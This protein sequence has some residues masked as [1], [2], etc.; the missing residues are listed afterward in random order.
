[1]RHLLSLQHLSLEEIF[2]LFHMT[3]MYKRNTSKLNQ[4]IFVANLFFEPST[5]TKMSFTVAQRKLGFEVLNFTPEH[6]SMTKGES[7]YDT[8]KTFEALGAHMLIIRHAANH[9]MNDIEPYVNIPV[10]NAGAGEVEH[11]TQ[12]LLDAFTI[13]EAFGRLKHVNV[14]IAG[15]IKHSRVAR[16]NI[17]LLSRLGANIYVSGPKALMDHTLAYPYLPI[18]E[19]VRCADSL[20]LLRIQHERH[21]QILATENYLRHYGLTKAREKMMK[22]N[23]IILHPAPVNRGVEIDQNL[24]LCDRSKIFQ[25]MTNGVYVRMAIMTKLLQY[26]GI[27]DENFIEKC[28]TSS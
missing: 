11:P 22:E 28:P 19:A 18:D 4:Q 8:V 10:I 1:M 12:S 14:V 13:Y 27:I 16:S 17:Q 3:R 7:L 9:W 26:W 25:Q 15:D 20:M 23:A 21:K 24:V 6:S 2:S 5:R